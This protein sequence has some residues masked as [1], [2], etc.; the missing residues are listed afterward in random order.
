MIPGVSWLRNPEWCSGAFDGERTLAGT[1]LSQMRISLRS[2]AE[3]RPWRLRKGRN[4]KEKL[5]L[6]EKMLD[7]DRRFQGGF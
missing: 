1:L 4:A 5:M 6:G 3:V 7:E 2:R